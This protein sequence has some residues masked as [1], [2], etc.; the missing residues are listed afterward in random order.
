MN[1]R[2]KIMSMKQL[3]SRLISA[4]TGTLRSSIDRFIL[5]TREQYLMLYGVALM[6]E[7]MLMFSRRRG[8]RF[9]TK[10]MTL[11]PCKRSLTA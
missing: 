9:F 5:K 1:K 7:P 6:A 8:M 3:P 4:S 10:G 11:M 2:V